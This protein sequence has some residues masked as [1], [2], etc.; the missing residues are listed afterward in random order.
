MYSRQETG[1]FPAS[2]VGIDSQGRETTTPIT[3]IHV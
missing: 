3:A 2:Q 1:A